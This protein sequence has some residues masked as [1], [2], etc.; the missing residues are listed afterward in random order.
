MRI[1]SVKQIVELGEIITKAVK[2]TDD[3]GIE[4]AKLIEELIPNGKTA[5]VF[6]IDIYVDKG[7]VFRRIKDKAV[8]S[9]HITIGTEDNINN[10]EEV[11][12]M[13]DGLSL[14]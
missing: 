14:R 6:I 3:R 11:D 4:C 7:K 10:Y 5:E 13:K 2:V 1:E 9:T 8:L 12:V